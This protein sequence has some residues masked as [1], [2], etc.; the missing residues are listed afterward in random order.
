MIS[1]SLLLGWQSIPSIEP[2]VS[3]SVSFGFCSLMCKNEDSILPEHTAYL[4]GNLETDQRLDWSS[5]LGLED[6]WKFRVIDGCKH[7]TSCT[8]LFDWSGRFANKICFWFP[9]PECF[10]LEYWLARWRPT[11]CIFLEVTIKVNFL[12][13]ELSFNARMRGSQWLRSFIKFQQ[14]QEFSSFL[15]GWVQIKGYSLTR[16][17]WCQRSRVLRYIH[18]DQLPIEYGGTN[19]FDGRGFKETAWTSR[20]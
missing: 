7:G 4:H 13:I 5:A 17:V 14:P 11:R 6:V 16:R 19:S 8:F 1:S 9:S 10:A 18:P 2:P 12:S 15:L 3:F 20:F